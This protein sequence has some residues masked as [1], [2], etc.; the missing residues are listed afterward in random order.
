MLKAQPP[1]SLPQDD[2]RGLLTEVEQVQ[3][4]NVIPDLE[5]P[6]SL[7]FCVERFLGVVGPPEQA[8]ILPPTQRLV[9]RS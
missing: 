4:W 7:Y 9:Y 3:E 8:I 5:V 1:K 6:W 2:I